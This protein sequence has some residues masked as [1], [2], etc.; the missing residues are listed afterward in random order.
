MSHCVEGLA[1][2]Q[3]IHEN[4]GICVKQICNSMQQR[5]EG[6]CSWTGGSESKLKWSA[7]GGDRSEGYMYLPT[8]ILSNILDNTGV[9]D[10]G[11]KSE[12]IVGCGFFAKEGY[13]LISIAEVQ[14]K[15]AVTS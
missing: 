5:Y 8:I 14:L 15:L 9:M 4:I 6:S 12:Q 1:E 7:G 13:M 11:R 2:I 10:M 3:G